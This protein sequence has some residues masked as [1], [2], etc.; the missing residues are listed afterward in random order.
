MDSRIQHIKGI[1]PGIFLE[2]ELKIKGLS[3]GPFALSIGEYPQTLSAIIHGKRRMNTSLALRIEKAL[4]M[5]IGTLM[6]IQV[7]HDIR[8]EEDKNSEKI[9]LNLSKL[10]AS[11]FWDT[12]V[13]KIDWIKHRQYVIE[14]VMERGTEDE[15][16]MISNFYGLEFRSN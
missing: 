11:L 4:G 12:D 6:L 14:R 10:R 7:Y 2:R 13:N 3:K 16:K 8:L 9:K 5:E 1:H 15:K